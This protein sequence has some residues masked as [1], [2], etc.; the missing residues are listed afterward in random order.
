M[1]CLCLPLCRVRP[2]PRPSVPGPSASA[3]CAA[4]RVC[5]VPRPLCLCRVGRVC[6]APLP[7]VPPGALC[8]CRVWGAGD[9]VTCFWC[10]PCPGAVSECG[11]FSSFCSLFRPDSSILTGFSHVRVF[12][13]VSGPPFGAAGAVLPAIV[14]FCPL[15]GGE[16]GLCMYSHAYRLSRTV[17]H[18]R[19]ERRMTDSAGPK[20][21]NRDTRPPTTT[22]G[23]NSRAEEPGTRHR[24]GRGGIHR[25]ERGLY[26]RVETPPERYGGGHRTG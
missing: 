20:K 13:Q 1:C 26:R 12:V 21:L 11:T 18:N 25:T 7:C 17:Q 2:R 23:P 4:R 10:G 5:R 24:L 3:V 22:R 14:L 15:S 6:L 16:T 19:I 8:L 9:R